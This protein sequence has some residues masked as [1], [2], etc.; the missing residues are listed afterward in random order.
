M[1]R[2]L[3]VKL[4][5]VCKY[6]LFFRAI[7]KL[8]PHEGLHLTCVC[9]M[10]EQVLDYY[11]QQKPDIVLLDSGWND[12]YFYKEKAINALLTT[13]PSCKIIL[14]S[15]FLGATGKKKAEQLGARGYFHRDADSFETVAACIKSV[16]N[17]KTY[18]MNDTFRSYSRIL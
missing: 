9:K 10:P 6:D 7:E 14:V 12:N 18:F 13:D 15:T 2:S 5:L 17:G 16:Y 1:T 3:K 11:N 8:L 4:L